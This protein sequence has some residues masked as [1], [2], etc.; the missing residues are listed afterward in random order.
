MK[1]ES[2][3]ELTD[4]FAVNEVHVCCEGD[5]NFELYPMQI[6]TFRLNVERFLLHLLV[7]FLMWKPSE[8][9]ASHASSD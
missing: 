4:E 7:E 5:Y 6:R 8:R 9:V 1:W 2:V 3:T